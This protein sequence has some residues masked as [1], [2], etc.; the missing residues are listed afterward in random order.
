MLQGWRDDVRPAHRI[1][2]YLDERMA[3]G[4]APNRQQKEEEEM[5]AHTISSPSVSRLDTGSFF[6]T[7]SC[8]FLWS[9]D[10]VP[11]LTLTLSIAHITTVAKCQSVEKGAQAC[12]AGRLSRINKYSNEP[13]CMLQIIGTTPQTKWVLHGRVGESLGFHHIYRTGTIQSVAPHTDF[14][15]S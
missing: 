2:E 6:D 13:Q 15:G 12:C 14:S 3:G 5:V 10:G 7:G 8:R 9:R 1:N 4:I 11:T